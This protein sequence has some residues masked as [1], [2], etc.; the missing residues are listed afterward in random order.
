MNEGCSNKKC[1]FSKQHI[2]SINYVEDC[3]FFHEEGPLFG[4]VTKSVAT[5]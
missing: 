5:T 3:E 4:C 2:L 1:L